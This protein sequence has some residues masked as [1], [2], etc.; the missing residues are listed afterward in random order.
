MRNIMSTAWLKPCL[1]LLFLGV[2]WPG[3]FGG[4]RC[5]SNR[6]FPPWRSGEAE[7][8]QKRGNDLSECREPL[9]E[10]RFRAVRIKKLWSVSVRWRKV[11]FWS[12]GQNRTK[13][14]QRMLSFCC[15]WIMKQVPGI[16]QCL[17]HITN[18]PLSVFERDCDH[19]MIEK[20]WK[21]KNKGHSLLSPSLLIFIIVWKQLSEYTNDKHEFVLIPCV[22]RQ[23]LILIL[24][25]QLWRWIKVIVLPVALCLWSVKGL[26]FDLEKHSS[27]TISLSKTKTCLKQEGKE[28][29]W[30]EWNVTWTHQ[31]CCLPNL[32]SS[33]FYCKNSFETR[34]KMAV[35]IVMKR[36]T[37]IRKNAFCFSCFWQRV[38]IVQLLVSMFALIKRKTKPK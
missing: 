5:S 2:L 18:N 38:W 13:T 11:L 8:C 25:I 29:E 1:L 15:V 9:Q 32:L 30:S 27:P 10:P 12:T 35:F 24:I 20:G 26:W 19:L 7:C 21:G 4:E 33:S 36:K 37:T 14:K 17:E 31:K 23:I 34:V 3:V 6:V 22:I 28:H 16:C